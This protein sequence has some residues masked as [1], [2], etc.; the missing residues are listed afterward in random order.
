VAPD[1]PER[2][3]QPAGAAHEQR[4]LA[5]H[6]PGQGPDE[7]RDPHVQEQLLGGPVLDGTLAN[8][9]NGIQALVSNAGTGTVGGINSATFTFWQNKV[10]SA[11]APIQGGG[12][13]TCRRRR[14]KSADAAPVAGSGPRRRQA[15][16]D[17]RGQQLLHVLRAVQVSIKRYTSAACAERRL[18]QPE[19]QGRGRDLRRRQRHPDQLHVLPE[20][21]LH[22]AG[23]PQ[24]RRH[25]DGEEM[26]PTTRTPS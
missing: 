1:R 12:A 6:Q 17:R 24:G 19:V 20:H 4:R 10:Q 26:R 16:P 5:H 8:Q 18:P 11:A 15:G 2:G 3:R 14:S 22:G 13:V 21:G 7:E 23:R 25:G 9:I